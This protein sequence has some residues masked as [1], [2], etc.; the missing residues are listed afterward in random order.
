MRSSTVGDPPRWMCPRTETRV[1]GL[2]ADD[3][4]DLDGGTRPL[5][6]NDDAVAFAAVI[7]LL[8]FDADLLEIVG[9]LRYEYDLRPA[10]N[11]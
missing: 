6:D 2:L 11:A 7:H 8:Q 4:T 10:G 9:D 5:R 3:L 1:F